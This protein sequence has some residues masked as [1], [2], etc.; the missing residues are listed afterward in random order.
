MNGPLVKLDIDLPKSKE[1]QHIFLQSDELLGQSLNGGANGVASHKNTSVNSYDY[2][3]TYTLKGGSQKEATASTISYHL[4]NDYQ[5]LLIYHVETKTEAINP[6]LL[7]FPDQLHNKSFKSVDIRNN[8]NLLLID[9]ILQNGMIICMGVPLNFK[10]TSKKFF[11]IFFP[12]DFTFK[13][14]YQL[15]SINNTYQI[16]TLKDGGILGLIKHYGPESDFLPEDYETVLFDKVSYLELLS[17][18]LFAFGS[19]ANKKRKL[20]N[21]CIVSVQ[22][23][24][25][26]NQLLTISNDLVL[27]LWSIH[28]A[29]SAF[30][31]Q[32]SQEINFLEA[33][34]DLGEHDIH[35]SGSPISAITED[36]KHLVVYLPIK[37]GVFQIYNIDAEKGSIQKTAEFSSTMEYGSLWHLVDLKILE[38][39]LEVICLWKGNLDGLVQVFKNGKWIS[40]ENT[41]FQD[42]VQ[43][44]YLKSGDDLSYSLMNLRCHYS[45]IVKNKL[46][47]YEDG[48]VKLDADALRHMDVQFKHAKKIRD[49]PCSLMLRN[50][51]MIIIN[52]LSIYSHSLYVP[53]QFAI[54]LEKQISPIKKIISVVEDFATC[55]SNDIFHDLATKF[56]AKIV[57]NKF[58]DFAIADL[59]DFK[60]CVSAEKLETLVAGFSSLDNFKKDLQNVI[61][62]ILNEKANKGTDLL[63]IQNYD[64]MSLLENLFYKISTVNR[65]VL[66]FLAAFSVL[67]FDYSTVMEEIRSLLRLHYLSSLFITLYKWDKILLLEELIKKYSLF[68]KGFLVQNYEQLNDCTVFLSHKI[69]NDDGFGDVFMTVYVSM[70]ESGIV[71]TAKSKLIQFSKFI[72]QPFSL[73]TNEKQQFF[74]GLMQYNTNNYTESFDILFKQSEKWED[75][76][77]KYI[78]T[79]EDSVH[80]SEFSELIKASSN[81]QYYYELSKK[82]SQVEQYDLSL[83]SVKKSIELYP[84]ASDDEH[85]E[86]LKK[87]KYNQTVQYL[88]TL[89]HFHLYKE[90]LEVLINSND[91]LNYDIKYD[92]YSNFLR[93]NQ[94]FIDEIIKY[95]FSEEVVLPL[96]DYDIVDKALSG[97]LDLANFKT[98]LILYSYRISNENSR[99]AIESLYEYITDASKSDSS[100]EENQRTAKT[101]IT[102]VLNS[103]TRDEDRWLT[104]KDGLV[105]TLK[106]L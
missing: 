22:Y 101:L 10:F 6:V 5:G 26:S 39:T 50:N 4:V 32:V 71:S 41:S 23:L 13:E 91:V 92:Y 27:K 79:P 67:E 81:T 11:R 74:L 104:T 98:Y 9:V 47:P 66:K 57:E 45:S 43:D 72:A 40:C 96:Q 76:P 85:D 84:E 49:E 59:E 73:I 37:S 80:L 48:L 69:L 35:S 86:D 106:D 58:Q 100:N 75:L 36:Q 1:I 68:E 25:S 52:N 51:S 18:K 88:I 34:E 105:L 83:Q 102:N 53:K 99:R 15:C 64:N 78:K 103:F 70:L 44:V 12:F 29:D 56:L 33:F 65:L 20:N 21:D 3:N 2:A 63:T 77:F 93:E 89:N 54:S 42:S 17:K 87:L 55:I 97:M 95:S 24:E 7:H 30:H 90:I 31:I 82:Y 94:Q 14:P 28:S 38:K 60:K 16:I 62:G 46:K 19:G 8:D 61:G